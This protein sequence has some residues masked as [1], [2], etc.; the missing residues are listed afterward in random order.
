VLKILP[1]ALLAPLLCAQSREF[2]KQCAQQYCA[3]LSLHSGLVT[4]AESGRFV[5]TYTVG[6]YVPDAQRWIPATEAPIRQT[7]TKQGWRVVIAAALD[8][9]DVYGPTMRVRV[10]DPTGRLQTT[11]D[12]EYHLDRVKIGNL[13]G[14]SQNVLA[15][16]TS[17]PHAYSVQ[18]AIW[19]LP[20]KGAMKLLA[21]VPGAIDHFQRAAPERVPGVWLQIQ[22]YDGVN[23]ITKGWRSEFWRWDGGI[24]SLTPQPD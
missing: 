5:P 19:L 1:I 24:D 11:H 23:A 8:E 2:S 4:F 14:T 12:G 10:F 18:A 17:G 15:V 13:L 3:V 21:E 6:Y 22:T 7:I 20:R 9:Y 16:V